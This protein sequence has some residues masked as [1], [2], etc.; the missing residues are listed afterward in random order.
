MAQDKS[1]EAPQMRYRPALILAGVAA[2]LALAGFHFFSYAATPWICL[3]QG[4]P[5]LWVGA[6][7]AI[8]LAAAGLAAG[9]AVSMQR[10][11]APE[12]APGPAPRGAFMGSVFSLFSGL[13]LLVLIGQAAATL[14]IDP[15]HK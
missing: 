8:L 7:A 15:C 6:A 13:L 3:R 11:G 14:L 10:G 2:P 4:L 9:L 12:D 1:H 5:L